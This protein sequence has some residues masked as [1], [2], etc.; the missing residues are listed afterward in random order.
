MNDLANPLTGLEFFRGIAQEHLHR[1]A[2]ISRMVEFPAQ[3]RYLP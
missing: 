2:A 3:H 1:V